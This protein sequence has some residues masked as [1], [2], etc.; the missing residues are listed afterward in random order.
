MMGGDGGAGATSHYSLLCGH[1]SFTVKWP[2]DKALD[3]PYI[4][5]L[6]ACLFL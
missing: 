4:S 3:F 6:L 5:M 1:S 2:G